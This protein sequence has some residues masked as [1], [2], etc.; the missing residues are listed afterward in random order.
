MAFCQVGTS[1][2]WTFCPCITGIKFIKCLN[3]MLNIWNVERCF[4]LAL[5]EISSRTGKILLQKFSAGSPLSQGMFVNNNHSICLCDIA[6]YVAVGGYL[7]IGSLFNLFNR[8]I[9]LPRK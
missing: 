4:R 1:L 3:K 2:L 9:D 6:V 8:A 5:V 7:L